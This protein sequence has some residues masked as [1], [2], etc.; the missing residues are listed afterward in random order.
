MTKSKFKMQLIG[1]L[2]LYFVSCLSIVFAGLAETHA[3]RLRLSSPGG[4]G[5]DI[6]STAYPYIDYIPMDV[7]DMLNDD[8]ANTFTFTSDIDVDGNFLDDPADDVYVDFYERTLFSPTVY[9]AE[10]ENPFYD[11]SKAAQYWLYYFYNDWFVNHIADWETITYFFDTESTPIEGIYSTHYEANRSAWNNIQP[12]GSNTKDLFV[13]NGG[14]GS[15][16][17]GGNTSY[18]GGK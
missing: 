5:V 17:F 12:N 8:R 18:T 1:I 13:S 16:S 11:N 15:Y 14:H 2:S 4:L 10:F 7:I 3:P 6:N 9:Y